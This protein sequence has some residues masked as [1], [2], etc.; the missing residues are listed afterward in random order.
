MLRSFRFPFLVLALLSSTLLVACQPKSP[1]EQVADT[2][3][4]YTVKLN[5]WYANVENE[6]VEPMD[7][8]SEDAEDGSED[9]SAPSEDPEVTESEVAEG[10]EEDA[11]SELVTGPQPHTVVFDLLVVYDGRDEPLPGVTVRVSHAGPDGA[12]KGSWLEFL[13]MADIPK[14]TSHQVGFEKQ[15]V[16]FEDG[17]QFA[18][19]LEKSVAPADYAQYPEFAS[20]GN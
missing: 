9:A 3:A 15:D 12:E 13:E 16:L 5:S 7:G 6:P 11:A 10:E 14:G 18:V 2:R 20:A 1:E 8:D 19:T 4:Q 17:D